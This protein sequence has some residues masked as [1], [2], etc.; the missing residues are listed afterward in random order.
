MSHDESTRSMEPK[1]VETP[2]VDTSVAFVAGS[3]SDVQRPDE[4]SVASVAP[5]GCDVQAS[6]QTSVASVAGLP[7]QTVPV[8]RP[9]DELSADNRNSWP[10]P[11]GAAAKHAL[12]GEIIAEISPH[13]ESDEA[14][15]L[16]QFLTIVGN[17]IGRSACFMAE[18]TPHFCNLFMVLVG[19]S[20]RS[21]KGTSFKRVKALFE[22]IDPDWAAKCHRSGLVSGEG[23]IHQI[24]DPSTRKA[25]RGEG[26]GSVVDPGCNDKRLLVVEEELARVLGAMGRDGNTLSEI[27][28]CAW[29]GV[30][31][32][33]L[34]KA[35]PETCREPH[36]SMIGHITKHELGKR[37]TSTDAA[38]G[39][40]NRI[41]WV[42]VKRSKL[43][44]NGAALGTTISECLMIRLAKAI[45]FAKGQ[46]RID[47]DE[48]A[49]TYWETIYPRLTADRF[50]IYGSITARAEAQVK[51]LAV[52]F[53]VLDMSNVIRVEHLK[54]AEECWR[55]SDESAAHTF[56]TAIGDKFADKI[57]AH[58]LAT[59][60]GLSLTE[61]RD[62]YQRHDSGRVDPALMTL[63]EMGLVAMRKEPTGGGRPRTVWF[64]TRHRCDKS[65]QSPV[66]EGDV[67]A[68]GPKL[69]PEPVRMSSETCDRSDRSVHRDESVA[70]EEE[71]ERRAIQEADGIA[72]TDR[73]GGAP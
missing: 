69:T 26:R 67:S 71:E 19:N 27:L 32:S 1:G 51:R 35:D 72:P 58:L 49:T 28:R 16:F 33:T 47:T 57:L 53:A 38:N 14:A 24:R 13:T 70:T 34:G 46:G 22:R 8:A 25:K 65:D 15:I 52:I 3:V 37:L 54:A 56:G 20:S 45:E 36:I 39:F 73:D 66:N 9:D 10:R 59:P 31:L 5:F 61:I 11:L 44:P 41:L 23:L 43:L 68:I 7:L 63:S 12:A 64:A 30:P 55:Y 40:G 50:G 17:I 62:K 2:S 60:K 29:D 48:E 42:C 21:R 4:A 18:S 6:E